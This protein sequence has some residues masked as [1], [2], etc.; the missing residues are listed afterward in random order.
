MALDLP[1]QL[2]TFDEV[3]QSK[4]MSGYKTPGEYRSALEQFPRD[5]LRKMTAQAKAPEW[6]RLLK[7][8]Q[9]AVFGRPENR[10]HRRIG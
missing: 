1:V 5:V 7:H 9:V 10:H 3:A 2:K 8:G 6:L 4:V